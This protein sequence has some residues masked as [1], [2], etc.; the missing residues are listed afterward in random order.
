MPEY[1]K[2]LKIDKIIDVMCPD[3]DNEA[4]SVITAVMCEMNTNVNDICYRQEIIEDFI[5]T[6]NYIYR[7]LSSFKALEE[8]EDRRKIT[9]KTYGKKI[10]CAYKLD[11]NIEIMLNCLSLM[12]EISNTMESYCENIS[13][14]GG[15]KL[16]NYIT[17]YVRGEDYSQ[18]ISL[19]KQLH[20]VLMNSFNMKFKIKIN[21]SFKLTEA[22]IIDIGS[23]PFRP[24][25]L[26]MN[27]EKS[28]LGEKMKKLFHKEEEK[29]HPSII[30]NIDFLIDENISEIREKAILRF[31][32]VI[33]EI[34]GSI[35]DFM[36]NLKL[37]LKFYYGAVNL[38]QAMSKYKLIMCKPEFLDS[39]DK[40][41][42][43]KDF[44]DLSF[45]LFLGGQNN[46][47][48]MSF[49]VSNDICMNNDERIFVVTGPNQGGK[50]TYI[51]AAGILQVLAQCGIPVPASKAKI[52][53]VDMIYTHF[54]VDEKPDSNAGRLGEELER[55]NSIITRA[56][57]QSMIL[58]NESFASTNSREGSIIAED[59]LKAL[60]II[61]SKVIFVT[62]LYELAEKV[63]KI[64]KEIED[65][66]PKSGKGKL[67]SL[68]AG[69]ENSEI[70]YEEKEVI[71]RR[72]YK[73]FKA[74]PMKSSFADDIARQYGISYEQLIKL[75]KV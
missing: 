60:S 4:R 69:I 46:P 58:M 26:S 51:R 16:Y 67:V 71:R 8:L 54:S 12:K 66:Y 48:P 9:V 53:P 28:N 13:S 3:K 15:K 33:S 35:Y 11:S 2:D 38:V 49:I 22:M 72:T 52:T 7:L 32:A 68:S 61:D 50:T 55:F 56:T 20:Q 29:N 65:K 21:K 19:L 6:P 70:N 74:P 41:F 30:N 1:I 42:E 64:N 43:M 37:E 34:T 23:Q 10:D 25:S 57:D 73:I 45:A 44:Y 5:R 36:Y 14:A 63:D 39:K 31:A 18:L 47:E 75:R 17:N 40:I 59:L 62:H 24:Q 27:G